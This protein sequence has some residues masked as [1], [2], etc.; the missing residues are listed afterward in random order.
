MVA[1]D[2]PRCSR[3]SGESEASDVRTDEYRFVKSFN[4]LM[5]IAFLLSSIWIFI[6]IFKQADWEHNLTYENAHKSA[7]VTTWKWWTVFS[8]IMAD[9]LCLMFLWTAVK[10]ENRSQLIL[11]AGLSYSF[12]IWGIANVYLRGSI[13]CFVI[14]FTI[15]TLS[16][17]QFLLQ[18]IED[19]EFRISQELR[20]RTGPAPSMESFLEFHEKQVERI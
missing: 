12:S 19:K 7:A 8:M 6:F 13:V 5:M 1:K 11:L 3:Y 20:E 4:L 15:A 18:R 10:A 2:A 16:V 14:P 17:L 9:F